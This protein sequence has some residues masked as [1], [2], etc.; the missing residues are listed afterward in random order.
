VALEGVADLRDGAIRIVGGRFDEEGRAAGPVRLVGDFLVRDALELA[1]ALLE[2]R[3]MLSSGI[4]SALAAS[5]A[6]RS[7]ALPPDRRRPAG[8]DRDFADQLGEQRAA[9]LSVTAFF[10]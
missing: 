4:F 2:A 1:R 7:R 5:M 9:P 10:R 6:V 3:S 8:S